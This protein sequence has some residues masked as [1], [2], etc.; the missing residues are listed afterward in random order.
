[1][2]RLAFVGVMAV[3]VAA[4]GSSSKHP[5]TTPAPPLRTTPAAAASTTTPRSTTP[6]QASTSGATNVRLPAIFTIGAG[7][8]LSPPVVTAPAGVTIELTLLS[9][10]GHAHLVT[11]MGRRFS[12]SPGHPASA[13][14]TRL[15]RGRYALVVDGA[16]RDALVI[17]GQPGP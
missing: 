14:L 17:G 15:R 12:V 6:P 2:R 9:G 3:V 11:F 16:T 4:C 1:M 8:K 13:R 7:G 10:D 5:A